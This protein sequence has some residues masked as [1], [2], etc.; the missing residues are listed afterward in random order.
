[1]EMLLSNP[2]P[3]E[4]RRDLVRHL[5][6]ALQFAHYEVRTAGNIWNLTRARKRVTVMSML[7]ASWR[8]RLHGERLEEVIT[9][10]GKVKFVSFGAVVEKTR[11]IR[12]VGEQVDY[13]SSQVKRKAGLFDE[14]EL[15]ILKGLLKEIRARKREEK[16]ADKRWAAWRDGV[17]KPSSA[18]VPAFITVKA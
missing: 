6:E 15:A 11:L 17:L 3:R 9:A 8:N 12:T 13:V 1:M 7:L 10:R 14:D 16:A 4:R 18:G 5:R 2:D